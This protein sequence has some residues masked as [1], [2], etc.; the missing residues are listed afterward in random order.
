MHARMCVIL[1]LRLYQIVSYHNGTNSNHPTYGVPNSNV[2]CSTLF[3][4]SCKPKISTRFFFALDSFA[5]TG[6][7]TNRLCLAIRKVI[8]DK[9]SIAKD[10]KLHQMCIY[11]QHLS[12][13]HPVYYFRHLVRQCSVCMTNRLESLLGSFH[14]SKKTRIHVT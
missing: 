3:S 12:L 2:L 1:I 5:Y 4:F 7:Y 10:Q 14:S 13:G 6:F 9:S 11:L 8:D